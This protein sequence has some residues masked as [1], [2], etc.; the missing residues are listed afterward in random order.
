LKKLHPFRKPYL[1]YGH[2]VFQRGRLKKGEHFLVHGG[3]SG[4]GIT[5]IQLA[6]LFG[7][8]VFTTAGTDEKCKACID[9]GADIAT[10]YNE[11]DFEQTLHDEGVDVILNMIGEEYFSKNIKLL[12]EE[13]RLIYINA[14]KGSKIPVNIF[15]IMQRRITISGSTLRSREI[16]FKAKL[17]VEVEKYIWPLVETEKFKPVV[18]KTF[19]LKDAAEAHRLMEQSSHIG[20]IILKVD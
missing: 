8:K 3:S 7:A 16:K 19:P 10:N 14:M 13:G 20:K 6:K 1:P 4:I 2:N 11:Q 5:A 17:A 15:E 9:L 12:N 18:F